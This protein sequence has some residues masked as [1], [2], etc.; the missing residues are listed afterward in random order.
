MLDV[1][2]EDVPNDGDHIDV[3]NSECWRNHGEV[4]VLRWWPNAPVKLEKMTTNYRIC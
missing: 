4:D 3:E 1:G 2:Q